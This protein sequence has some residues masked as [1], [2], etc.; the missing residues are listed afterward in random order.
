MVGGTGWRHYSATY[1]KVSGRLP[2]LTRY[3]AKSSNAW[4]GLN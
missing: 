1:W 3:N 2:V 4:R